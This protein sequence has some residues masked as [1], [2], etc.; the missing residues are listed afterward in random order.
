[1]YHV[2]IRPGVKVSCE[3]PEEVLAL[4]E[5]LV[6][7]EKE[8]ERRERRERRRAQHQSADG[9]IQMTKQDTTGCDSSRAELPPSQD[10]S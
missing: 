7:A 4:V 3:K 10:R 1:M 6:D 2:E 9:I 8:R 5:I